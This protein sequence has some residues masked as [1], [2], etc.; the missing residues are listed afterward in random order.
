MYSSLDSE[1]FGMNIFRATLS[2]IHIENLKEQII[3]DSI[4]LIILRLPSNIKDK[5]STLHQ[6]GF[7]IIHAD[8]LVYYVSRLNNDI[9]PLRNDL[10][11]ETVNEGNKA[12]LDEIVPVIFKDYTNH[13][14]CNPIFDKVKISAGYVEWAKSY[15][16][17]LDPR[18]VSWLVKSKNETI[19]FATCSFDQSIMESEGVLYGV[20]PHAA[21]KGIYSDIMRFTMGY[22]KKMNYKMMWVSTQ[23]QNYSVQK[24]WIKEGFQLKKSFDTY[25]II[26]KK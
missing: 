1:R 23:I 21:G 18:R 8:T 17:N 12:I 16:T 24:A 22:F 19:G 20:M 14:A 2:D 4:D 11:F 6:L 10:S 13:Y 7:Q 26:C 5:H 25:H 9:A 15:L 3:T